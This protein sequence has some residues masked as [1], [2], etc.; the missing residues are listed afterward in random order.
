MQ[1]N[2]G[3]YGPQMGEFYSRMMNTGGRP[4]VNQIMDSQARVYQDMVD[5]IRAQA[6][7]LPR[8]SGQSRYLGEALGQA[9]N[10]YNLQQQQNL[11]DQNQQAI[12]NQFAGAQGL[13]TLPSYYSQPSSFEMQMLGLQQPYDLANQQA[14]SNSQALQASLLASLLQPTNIDYTVTPSQAEQML[15]WLAPLLSGLGQGFSTGY[16]TFMSGGNYG[17]I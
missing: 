8:G 4:G 12:A 11:L 16:P 17:D 1:S 10:Q 5:Q 13:G 15:G 3:Q 7:V 9:T 2:I 6:G 14:V